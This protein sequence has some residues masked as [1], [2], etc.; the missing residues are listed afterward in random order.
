MS[1][2]TTNELTVEVAREEI[3]K[4]ANKHKLIF[5]DKGEVG[6]G[7]PCVGLTYGNNY[8]NY[9]PMRHP[10]YKTVPG[11][12]GEW[13][14]KEGVPDAY[15]KHDCVAVLVSSDN[16]D[17]A[18]IQLGRWVRYL[19]AY[20]VEVAEFKTGATGIQVLLSGVT[21]KALRRKA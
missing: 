8:L 14:P 18:I 10:D 16:Y 11:F 7:R 20:G 19:E 5:E 17:E 13:L 2:V 9:N 1:D 4:F 6:F 15:H 21:G 12:E 3:Q